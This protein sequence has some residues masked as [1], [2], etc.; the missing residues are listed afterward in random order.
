M[1]IAKFPSR[2]DG[3]DVGAW[4]GVAHELATRAGVQ[5]ATAQTRTF[6][7]EHHTFLAQ[8]FDRTPE[9]GR[10][11]FVSAM[12]LLQRSD[13]DDAASGVSYLELAELI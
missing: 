5:T 4:E 12:T 11:H 2:R 13:G 8:R 1:W 9:G 7:S 3:D 6:G 10:L